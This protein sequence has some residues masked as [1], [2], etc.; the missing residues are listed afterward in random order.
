MGVD[1]AGLALAA[2]GSA[3]VAASFDS[4]NLTE[5][6]PVPRPA[7]QHPRL[8]RLHGQAV[9]PDQRSGHPQ[10]RQ[11]LLHRHRLP[12]GRPPRPGDHR[13]L[14][15]LAARARSPASA[16]ARTQ[17]HRA[18]ARRARPLRLQHRRRSAA[19]VR[20]RRR[21]RRG[22]ARPPSSPPAAATAWRWTAPATSTCRPA[23]T[24]R[25][26]APDGKVLGAIT[27]LGTSRSATPPSAVPTARPCSSPRL[28]RCTRSR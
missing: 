11:H 23:G 21:R 19:P 8:R 18:V 13:P 25:V 7:H 12:P 15:L 6:D 2:Q 1:V 4:R 16:P 5:F 17:R 3:I 10:R 14:P 22:R 20:P 28:R 27:G 26:L 9:R 24:I